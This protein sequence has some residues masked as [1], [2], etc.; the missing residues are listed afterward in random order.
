M[1]SSILKIDP[2]VARI[3]YHVHAFD[4]CSNEEK[5]KIHQMMS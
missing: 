1:R 4:K 5:V 3:L 2:I